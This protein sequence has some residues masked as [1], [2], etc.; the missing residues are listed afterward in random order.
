MRIDQLCESFG[1]HWH[2]DAN[3]A[4][5]FPAVRKAQICPEVQHAA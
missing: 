3:P 4:S 2:F 5:L 1:T